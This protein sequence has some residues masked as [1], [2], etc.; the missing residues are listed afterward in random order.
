MSITSTPPVESTAPPATD[1]AATAHG[2]DPF[3]ALLSYVVPGL[4]QIYQGRVGKGVLFMVCLLGLFIYGM[5]LGQWSNVYLPDTAER[6]NSWNLPRPLANV[7]N[8]LPFAGQFWIGAAAWPAI[9]QYNRV[10]APPYDQGT[11]WDNFQ[12]TPPESKLNELQ[13][14]G[15]KSWDM[16]WVYTVIAGV[17]NVLVIYDALAGA[18]FA[19]PAPKPT[20]REDEAVPA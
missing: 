1:T 11:F 10:N 18:A 12:R 6:N 9:W 19:E 4:G 15:D 14:N 5:K 13:A 2:F 16:G 7:A 8:R 3:A 17:L 20:R